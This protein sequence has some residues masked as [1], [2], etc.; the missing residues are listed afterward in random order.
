MNSF[1]SEIVVFSGLTPEATYY[2][3]VVAINDAQKEGYSSFIYETTY[4]T[5]PTY[6]LELSGDHIAPIVSLS[7]IR[8][9]GNAE[10]VDKITIQVSDSGNF[11]NPNISKTFNVNLTSMPTNVT[12]L[13][14]GNLP[15]AP[16]LYYRVIAY[17]DAGYSTT[18]DAQ[19]DLTYTEG[20]NVWSGL[21][22]NIS[23]SNAY[24]FEGGLP[25]VDKKLYFNRPAG[26]S[27]VINTDTQMPSL[28]FTAQNTDAI[29]ASYLGGFHSCGY[30]LTGTGVLTFDA[31]KPILQA[32]KGTNVVWNPIVF[33]RSNSQTV[34][35]SSQNGRLDLMGDL[36][37]P[38]GVSNTTIRIN[39]EGGQVHLGGSSLDFMGTLHVEQS[40][41]LYLDNTNA[42]T[43]VKKI[44]YDGGWG[45]FTYINNNTGV[46]MVFPLCETLDNQNGWSCT[47][48][49]YSGA[50]FIF[51]NATVKWRPRAVDSSVLS[52]DMIVK[53]LIVAKHGSNGTAYF[54]KLGA[55]AFIVT[56]TTEWDTSDCK[57]FIRLRGGCYYPETI[58]GL[59]P[60][61]EFY[62]IDSSKFCTLGLNSDYSPMLDGSST[63]R[64]FLA[65]ETSRFGFTGFG[66]DR[67]VCWN[68]D[69]TLNLT[70][71]ATDVVS[72][73][74]TDEVSLNEDGKTYS[75]YY[76]YPS[77]FMFGN[78]SEFADG[79][80]IFQNPIRYELGQNWST[81]TY[82]ESTNHVV[83]ARLRGSLK[84]GHRD[85]TWKFSGNSFGGYLALEAEN[86]DFTGHVSVLDKGNLLVNSNLVARSLTVQSGSGLGGTGDI[87]TGDGTTIKSGG[88]LFGGEWNKGG[89]LLLD[90]NVT[91]ESGSALRVEVGE[92]MERVGCVEL[93][94]DSVLKLTAPIYIDVDTD[95]RISPIRGS[96]QKILDWSATT[97]N[98]GAAPKLD[99]FVVRPESNPDI[100]QIFISV[101][102]DGLYVGYVSK[103][104]PDVLLILVK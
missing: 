57:H 46:P 23:E 55:G 68:A 35:I 93:S 62:V 24:I 34:Y 47:R 94:Q 91:L 95:P 69:P 33:N 102:E 99:D 27:P 31:E 15:V 3:R 4:S 26:L 19:V 36:M 83:S 32:S 101:R 12:D 61:G 65:V 85:K 37:L 38:E 89:T 71:T 29:D 13:V 87:S 80:I 10:K 51:P 28:R 59:P 98:S 54:D 84:L 78:R 60:S 25:N 67:T 43:N 8:A 42:L 88:A 48:V 49:N 81:T 66:G 97:F 56:D 40:F 74:L 16:T 6:T 20:D 72:L 45:S 103:R 90:G 7:F 92:S 79:T 9:G 52:A 17:N 30:N 50:P 5:G 18:I 14:L 41:T 2:A 53:N 73:K 77:R 96:S 100:S 82:F 86:T 76:A 70:N 104:S 22:E 1:G 21:S 63:P 64:I 75:T 11:M 39:G 44:F 58:A